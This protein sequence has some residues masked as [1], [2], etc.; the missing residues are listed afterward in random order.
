M[1]RDYTVHGTGSTVLEV[2]GNPSS[3]FSRMAFI[4]PDYMSRSIRHVAFEAQRR[5]KLEFLAHAPGGQRIEPITPVQKYRVLDAFKKHSSRYGRAGADGRKR[6]KNAGTKSYL[7]KG[8][9]LAWGMGGGKWPIGGKLAQTIGYQMKPGTMHASVGWLSKSAARMG[10]N[11]QRGEKQKITPKMRGLFW[12]AG[13]KL[14]GKEI[15]SQPAR[16]VIEPFFNNRSGWMLT[17]LLNRMKHHIDGAA[18]QEVARAMAQTFRY[19]KWGR[20]I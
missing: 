14:S 18:A 6:L 7:S 4:Y 13:V 11:F 2:K 16:P 17:L 10:A 5:L 3:F 19:G 8:R 9:G 1:A 12:A 15:I 20:A